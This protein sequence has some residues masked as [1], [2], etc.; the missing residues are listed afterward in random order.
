MYI[1]FDID[2]VLVDASKRLA[3]C[4]RDGELDL[5]CFLDCAKLAMDAPLPYIELAN[6]LAERFRVVVVTGRPEYMRKCTEEQL[7]RYGLSFNGLFMRPNKDR[8]PDPLYKADAISRLIG[9]GIYILVHFEDNRDTAKAL[10]AR[11]I[12][13]VLV[14]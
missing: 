12:D 3:S 4:M 10:R 1:S 6:A 2:G 5:S 13:V 11:G 7:G 14:S 8:R 9:E